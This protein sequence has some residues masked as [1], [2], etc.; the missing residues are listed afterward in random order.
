MKDV[1]R[2]KQEVWQDPKH[3]KTKNRKTISTFFMPFDSLW[4]DIVMEWLDDAEHVLGFKPDDPLFPKTQMRCN[5]ETLQFEVAGLSREHWANTTPIRD[6]F[7]AGFTQAGLPY[8][9]PHSFRKMLTVWALEHCT[10]MEFKA[11]SQNIGHEHAMTTYNAYGTLNDHTRRNVI[12]GI[13]S[14]PTELSHVSVE[15]LM[16]EMQRRMNR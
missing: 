3:V 14:T 8:Y 2:E 12:V 13:A 16:Q 5:P 4:L 1:N 7:K 11:I 15:V 6:I 9:N 10:Q